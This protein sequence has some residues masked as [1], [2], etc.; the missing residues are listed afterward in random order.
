MKKLVAVALLMS[1]SLTIYCQ[2]LHLNLFGG[3]ANYKGDL[4]YNAKGGKQISFKQ[5]KL[6]AGAGLEYELSEKMYIR[7]AITTGKIHADDKRQPGQEP[8]NLNFTSSIF[9]VMLGLQYYIMDPYSHKLSPYVFAGI[10]FFHFKPYT[11]GATGARVFLQ[12]L[13]TEGQGFVSGREPYKLSQFSVPFGG[14][15]KFSLSDDVRVGVEMSLRKTFTDY[16]DDVSTKYV[17]A[18]VLLANR[19]QQAVDF[20]YRGEEVGSGPYPADGTPRGTLSAKD[21][22]YFTGVTLS[23]RLGS[24]GGG[25]GG[26]RKSKT[27]CPVIAR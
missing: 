26:G 14:G 15:I 11:F 22:Y 9:D 17:E 19:G 7:L 18:N 2:N 1:S 5:P 13:S 3:I 20:A 21:W 25:G 23:Y 12:P 16:L 6:A 27:G 10:G 4:Q 24:G 8:R